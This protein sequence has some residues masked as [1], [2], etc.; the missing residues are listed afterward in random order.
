L[1][2]SIPSRQRMADEL[3]AAFPRLPDNVLL[4]GPDS[5][6]STYALARLANAALIYGTKT[7]IELTCAGVPTIVA[8]EAWIRGKGLTRD[9]NSRE[10]YAQALAELPFATALPKAVVESALRFAFHFFFRRMIPVGSIAPCP[11][12]PPYSIGI[13][14]LDDLAPGRDPGLDV[15]VRGLIDEEPFIYPAE[16]NGGE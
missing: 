15:I 4:V 2:G 6:V 10:E 1:T 12:W 8:G 5:A 11:G 3:A 7:G 9:V 14:G 16:N 13:A